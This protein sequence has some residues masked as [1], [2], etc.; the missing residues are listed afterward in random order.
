LNGKRFNSLGSVKRFLKRVLSSLIRGDFRLKE[1]RADHTR[2]LNNVFNTQYQ[3]TALLSY[4]QGVFENEDL[5][6]DVRHTNRHTTY[7]IAE[8]LK[9]L[10]YNVDVINYDQELKGDLRTYSFVFGLGKS[11]EYIL[12][13]RNQ[14]Q[15]KIIYFATGCNPLFSNVITLSRIEDFY[16]RHKKVFFSSSRYIIEDWPLQHELADWI[17]LHGNEFA[18]ST[19]RNYNITA[20][21][22]PVFLSDPAIKTDW[23]WELS[24]KN[25]LWFG[26]DGAIHKGLDLL[27]EAF[28][29]YPDCNLVVCGS[30][31]N[32]SDLIEYYKSTIGISSNISLLGYV[33]V[34]S[35]KFLEILLNCAF[36]ISP[37]ASEGNS[38]SV[39]TCMA[40]GGLIPVISRNSDVTLHDYGVL[41]NELTIESVMDS[42]EE[43]QEI[44]IE[45]LKLQS[46]KVLDVSRDLHS[47]ETFEKNFR[48]KLQEALNQLGN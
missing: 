38:P 34:G 22:G 2:I 36:V 20:I 35:E 12:K 1:V 6:N 19:Y 44:S 30:L 42:I 24:R 9:S 45:E 11:L 4:I 15:P 29:K 33:T 18:K 27:I 39:L 14:S 40:N 32:D 46:K 16:K 26:S 25:Y 7:L 10:N 31:Q 21:N 47:F 5:I 3:E 23:Q 28:I 48:K 8:V 37:S 13:T 43:S 41:I 17:I